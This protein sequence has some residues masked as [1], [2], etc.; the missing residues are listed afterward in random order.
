MA[1]ANDQSHID[2][3]DAEMVIGRLL[4]YQPS[5]VFLYD[6]PELG[7]SLYDS[8]ATAA[9]WPTARGCGRS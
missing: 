4:A 3:K 9:A 8:H 5:D 6:H 1:Y 2:A 7:R